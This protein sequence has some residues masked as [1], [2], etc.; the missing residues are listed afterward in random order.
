[1]V[2]RREAGLVKIV[3]Q[4]KKR[5]PPPHDLLLLPHDLLL[6]LPQP[7]RSPPAAAPFTAASRRGSPGASQL[8]EPAPPRVAASARA[9]HRCLAPRVAGSLPAAGARPTA[10]RRLRPRPSPLPCAAGRREPPSRG[11]PPHRGSPPPPAPFTA[12]SRRQS[13][14]KRPRVVGS[15]PAAGAAPPRV[16][17]SAKPPLRHRHAATLPLRRSRKISEICSPSNSYFEVLLL[18][19]LHWRKGTGLIGTTDGHRCKNSSP[20]R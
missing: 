6:L 8:R 12:A 19:C 16:A 14:G 17:A 20:Q 10:G 15:L 11:S 18:T 3:P 13:H 9:L 2:L 5:P 7:R 4:Q 1:M